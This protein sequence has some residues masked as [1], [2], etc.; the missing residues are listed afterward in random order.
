M[1]IIGVFRICICYVNAGFWL[2]IYSGKIDVA[3]DASEQRNSSNN[4][5]VMGSFATGFMGLC[6]YVGW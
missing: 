1:Q 2:D 6:C 3:S 5:T 4:W